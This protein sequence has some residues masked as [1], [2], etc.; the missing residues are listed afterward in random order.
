MNI[1]QIVELLSLPS[2]EGLCTTAFRDP[3]TCLRDKAPEILGRGCAGSTS[4]LP[5]LHVQ[6]RTS[7]QQRYSPAARYSG[8]ANICVQ[9]SGIRRARP[10][11]LTVALGA[12]PME[13]Q[14]AVPRSMLL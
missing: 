4:G 10:G 8:C 6:Q 7:P 5:A 2:K 12:S 13:G 14:V 9:R 1:I 11:L 3:T